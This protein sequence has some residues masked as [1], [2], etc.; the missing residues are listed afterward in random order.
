MQAPNDFWDADRKPGDPVLEPHSLFSDDTKELGN[1][2]LSTHL[3]P[4]SARRA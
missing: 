1:D 2:V 3:W 4:I